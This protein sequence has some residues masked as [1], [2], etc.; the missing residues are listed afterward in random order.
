MAKI[1]MT[2]HSENDVISCGVIEANRETLYRDIKNSTERGIYCISVVS[3]NDGFTNHDT[4]FLP[5][6]AD[7]I[8]LFINNLFC[9]LWRS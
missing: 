5:T 3:I 9:R 6:N 4:I 2:F 8:E 1:S 7:Q